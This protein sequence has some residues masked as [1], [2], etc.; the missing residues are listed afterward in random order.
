M[1]EKVQIGVFGIL[2]EYVHTRGRTPNYYAFNYKICQFGFVFV[3][4]NLSARKGISTSTFRVRA[5]TWPHTKLIT[6]VPK[7][8]ES[9]KVSN[10]SGNY[11][12]ICGNNLF[13]TSN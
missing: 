10:L 13:F 8:P 9:D 1:Q 4:N 2:S 11:S 7:N 6:H 12:A 5:H 3:L